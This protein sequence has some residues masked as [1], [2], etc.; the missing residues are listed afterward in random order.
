MNKISDNAIN[1]P[2]I[3][4]ELQA[5]FSDKRYYFQDEEFDDGTDH[6]IEM[7]EWQTEFLETWEYLV[8]HTAEVWDY[9]WHHTFDTP[10]TTLSEWL[11]RRKESPLK[12]CVVEQFHRV[13]NDV[14]LGKSGE[15]GQFY[16]FLIATLSQ[17]QGIWNYSECVNLQ[18]LAE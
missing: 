4:A 5:S 13:I 11:F 1:I 6:E 2:K 7:Q 10:S 14:S 15:I 3:I 12:N 17:G 9:A 16:L 8:N 18:H